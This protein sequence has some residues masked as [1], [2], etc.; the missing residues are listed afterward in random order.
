MQQTW[1]SM[2]PYVDPERFAAVSANLGIQ[3]R[4][5]KWWR[6]AS[7]AYFQSKSGLTLPA[8]I[9]PPEHDLAY[10]KSLQF[11]YAPGH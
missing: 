5:A 10:Y 4:E 7:I 9:T 11:P 2:K 1:A 3:T 8:G 6:D